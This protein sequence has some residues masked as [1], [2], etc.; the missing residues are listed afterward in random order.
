[1]VVRGLKCWINNGRWFEKELR[2]TDPC[3]SKEICSI[4]TWSGSVT[5]YLHPACECFHKLLPNWIHICSLGPCYLH[6]TSHLEQIPLVAVGS[7]FEEC[8]LALAFKPTSHVPQCKLNMRPTSPNE[9][10][11]CIFS[12]S[13]NSQGWDTVRLKGF[14]D[15]LV[16]DNRRTVFIRLL[17]T[18]IQTGRQTDRQ[19]D[20]SDLISIHL[21]GEFRCCNSTTVP[22]DGT[23]GHLHL[24][25]VEYIQL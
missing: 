21:I 20:W 2:T 16:T 7:L 10:P 17:I 3:R 8:S 1:M 4:T 22:V 6:P 12:A 23:D 11:G 13:L 18:F 25:T 14:G 19:S 15:N 5:V 9:F 24:D